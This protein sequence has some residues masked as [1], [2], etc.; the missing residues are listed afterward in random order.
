MNIKIRGLER[1]DRATKDAANFVV[2]VPKKVA[3]VLRKNFR[4]AA[5]ET[6]PR[7]PVRTGAVK[8]LFSFSVKG[9]TDRKMNI[10][11]QIGFIR[12]PVSQHDA[13]PPH[14]FEKG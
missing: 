13:V 1:L 12:R 5:S 10:S 6:R 14:V 9:G 4:R 11:G 2:A 3:E 7:I 8:R